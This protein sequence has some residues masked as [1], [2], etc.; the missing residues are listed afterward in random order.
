[1]V[2]FI[3]SEKKAVGFFYYPL[4]EIGFGIFSL[5]VAFVFIALFL[6]FNHSQLF[7]ELFDT[8]ASIAIFIFLLFLGINLT[9]NYMKVEY[10]GDAFIFYQCMTTPVKLELERVEWQG[11]RTIINKETEK[12]DFFV[13]IKLK[14]KKGDILF[15]NTKSESEADKI[16]SA[17][18][19]LHREIST[20]KREDNA[21]ELHT[22]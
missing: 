13:E 11:V 3:F 7:K 9:K 5:V 19:K 17:L 16:V 20:E 1:M 10:N 18:T 14:T 12:S 6:Y 4:L 15:Y 2:K 8:V 21:D 22:P